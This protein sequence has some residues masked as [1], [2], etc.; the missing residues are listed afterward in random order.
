MTVRQKK[1]DVVLPWPPQELSP[2]HKLKVHWK[3]LQRIVRNY[4]ATSRIL[5]YEAAQR[6]RIRNVVGK[7]NIEF[8]FYPPDNSRRDEDN[9][10]ATMKA[11]IDG[12]ADAICVNDWHFHYKEMT[13]HGA[14]PPGQVLA[15]VSFLQKT[16]RRQAKSANEAQKS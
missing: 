2:N 8:H 9:L 3:T 6:L 13:I 16:K 15:R 10:L 4:R 1:F 7:V 11:G 14:C 5:T 12:I